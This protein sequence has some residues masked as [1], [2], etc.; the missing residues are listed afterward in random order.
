MHYVKDSRFRIL[1]DEKLQMDC[2]YPKFLVFDSL[3]FSSIFD[4]S[5]RI[6]QG[7]IPICE[8][9]KPFLKHEKP[10]LFLGKTHNII[11]LKISKNA[12]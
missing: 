8:A 6:E 3:N 1:S 11:A 5:Q 12:Q 9:D 4:L 10:L 7:Q 2:T